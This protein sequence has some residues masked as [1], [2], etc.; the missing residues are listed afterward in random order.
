MTAL[1]DAP[2]IGC[3]W[4]VSATEYPMNPTGKQPKGRAFGAALVF[5]P[6]LAFR[7]YLGVAVLPWSGL[8]TLAQCSDSTHWMAAFRSS[9]LILS[10]PCGVI[11]ISPQLPLPPWRTLSNSLP[12]ALLSPWYLAA[13]SL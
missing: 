12:G 11:G 5:L 4:P 2:Q 8:T 7:H 9:S 13:T 1:G 10:A 6:A 3:Y